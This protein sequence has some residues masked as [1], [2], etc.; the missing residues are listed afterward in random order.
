MIGEPLFFD[1]GVDAATEERLMRGIETIMIQV[2]DYIARSPT[3][4]TGRA[5]QLAL[6]VIERA[7][8]LPDRRS[9]SKIGFPM[10]AMPLLL[11][12]PNRDAILLVLDAIHERLMK[13]RESRLAWRGCDPEVAEDQAWA[14]LLSVMDMKTPPPTTFHA[15]F[16]HHLASCKTVGG[17]SGVAL[18]A[19]GRLPIFLEPAPRKQSLQTMVFNQAKR[20]VY[21]DRVFYSAPGDPR[22]DKVRHALSCA[23]DACSHTWCFGSK[24][25]SAHFQ[26]CMY[27]DKCAICVPLEGVMRQRR[28]RLEMREQQPP[29]FCDTLGQNDSSSAPPVNT[30][31]RKTP[32]FS[33]YV[34]TGRGR[35]GSSWS[36]PIAVDAPTKVGGAPLVTRGLGASKPATTTMTSEKARI[37]P[38]L[39]GTDKPVTDKDYPLISNMAAA[40]VPIIGKATTT[41]NH[42]QVLSQFHS[43]ADRAKASWKAKLVSSTMEKSRPLKKRRVSLVESVAVDQVGRL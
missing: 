35:E 22:H 18:V 30:P 36:T 43:I 16:L 5:Y 23:D 39:V 41:V 8:S 26:A 42:G 21:L 19:P 11:G 34:L 6:A 15:C 14:L 1:S 37:P 32:S 40:P 33:P 28:A 7:S 25:A 3:T 2:A 31:P 17:V 29:P 24:C 38:A 4:S 20:L 12:N 10:S 9:L 27:K 13:I